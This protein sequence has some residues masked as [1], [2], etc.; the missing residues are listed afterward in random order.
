[1]QSDPGENG[2]ESRVSEQGEMG[3]LRSAVITG[4]EAALVTVEVCRRKGGVPDTHIVGM[5][6]IAVRE[7]L[8]RVHTACAQSG[9]S[10][11]AR[12]TTINLAPAS[13]PKS[14]AGLDLPIAL[15]MMIADQ[16][17][18]PNRLDGCICLGEL[19]LDGSVRAVSGVL[20]T[21]LAAR[22]SG[23]TRLLVPLENAT[24]VAEIPQ[25]EA[26]GVKSLL[27]AVAYL[28]GGC[29]LHPLPRPK[30][31]PPHHSVDLKDIV[32]H[33]LPRRALELAAAGAHH[34][35][36]VG[37]PGVGKTLLARALPGI[38][39]PLS[40]DEAVETSAVYSVI[41]RLSGRGLMQQRP[42]RAPHHSVTMAGL[43]GGGVPPRPGEL[44]LAHNGV[45]F[46]DEFPEFRRNA[47]ESLR[48][49]LE[50]AEICL[51]RGGQSALLPTR[52]QLVGSMNPCPCGRGPGDDACRCGEARLA[53]YWQ[54]I[55][56]PLLD[57]I[58]IFVWVDRVPLDPLIR[59]RTR[60]E[61]SAQVRS[62]IVA[63]R[64]VQAERMSAL[65]RQKGTP[66]PGI[67]N[68]ALPSAWLASA[69][70]LSP[71]VQKWASGVAEQMRLSAR[72]WHRVLR[73]ARSIA[74]IEGAETIGMPHLE[75]ALQYRQT[76]ISSAFQ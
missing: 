50:E 57:R 19:G 27:Q 15:G 38:L 17:L 34:L 3:R 44:S 6:G 32:G 60:D 22:R 48:Q 56:G 59:G 62:R 18:A 4:V 58:D 49:P 46:L 25:I 65:A 63:A 51:V 35:L 26:I 9:L 55:S 30:T 28:D 66:S 61:D 5:P 12:K 24:E 16:R 1:M 45:L 36:M 33:V 69:C 37:P 11:S 70:S 71:A 10:L 14:G 41:G 54:R 7:S 23:M 72:A 52:F 43:V 21:A 2:E 53:R 31:E 47:L 67:T 42:F 13:Q 29:P 20:P 64:H 68:S 8:D 75:E 40:F 74:D 39:P 76:T 73:V